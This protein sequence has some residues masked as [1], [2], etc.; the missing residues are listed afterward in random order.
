MSTA[1]PAP[2]EPATKPSQRKPAP[3]CRHCH[4]PLNRAAQKVCGVCQR[5]Q[6]KLRRWLTPSSI[7]SVLGTVVSVVA[8]S[9][10]FGQA[11]DA[12]AEATNAIAAA[13]TAQE[14]E[15]RA[16]SALASAQSLKL[17]LWDQ[18][19]ENFEDRSQAARELAASFQGASLAFRQAAQRAPAQ[20]GAHWG[21]L[22]A[23]YQGMG[24]E[25]F[26]RSERLK[27]ARAMWREENPRPV[28][29]AESEQK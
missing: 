27:K 9:L 19:D 28:E 24:Q 6:S 21:N 2:A 11:N 1:N 13:K 7:T 26:K 29:T 20:M 14:A 10:A 15:A 12:R 16:N 23:V 4:A 5:D 3:E 8:L 25:Q 17:T 22:G 18:R